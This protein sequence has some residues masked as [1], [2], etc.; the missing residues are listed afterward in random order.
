[1]KIYRPALGCRLIRHP[2]G[3]IYQGFGESK[4]LYAASVCI[5]V[6]KI[7]MIGGHNGWDISM[8]EGTP[9]LATTGKVVEVKDTPTGYGKHVRILTAPDENGVRYELT[10]GHLKDINVSLGMWVTD[11][12]QIGTM[13]NT[14]FVVSGSTPYWGNAPAGKGVHLHFGVRRL[15][16]T[17][18]GEK[19]FYSTG[20]SGAI[21]NYNN[22]TFGSIDPS[23]Y[24]D[25]DSEVSYLRGIILILA[26]KLRDALQSRINSLLKT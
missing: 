17:P 10:Y 19:I 14:G 23:P 13:G 12:Q 24:F 16:S 3:H 6:P 4:E 21:E 5:G 1:M 18:S 7:C 2:N 8:N 22:G 25:Y 15:L 11:G 9:I 20:D 26:T